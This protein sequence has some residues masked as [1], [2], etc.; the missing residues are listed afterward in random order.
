MDKA[1]RPKTAQASISAG[2]GRIGDAMNVLP[3]ETA[4]GPEHLGDVADCG[5]IGG[6]PEFLQ[7]L[8]EPGC[9][10]AL[11]AICGRL[12]LGINDL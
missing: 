4:M 11:S 3:G 2:L 6:V 1:A 9:L 7:R 10:L 5:G 8:P 12:P